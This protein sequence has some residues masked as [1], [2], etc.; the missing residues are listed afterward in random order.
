MEIADFETLR[1]IALIGV[2]LLDDV[3]AAWLAAEYEAER[4]LR[5]W[6]NASGQQRARASAAYRAA[7]DREEAAARELERLHELT[8]SCVQRLVLAE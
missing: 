1:E 5:S 4:A 7:L 3:E 8:R 2:D 6:L